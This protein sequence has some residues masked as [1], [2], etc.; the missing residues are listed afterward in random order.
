M[1]GARK[2]IDS[3]RSPGDRTAEE[4]QVL[5]GQRIVQAHLLLQLGQALGRDR[6][7]LGAGQHQL[8]RIARQ[9][10]HDREAR[11]AR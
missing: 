4:T 5:H 7:A 10:V 1:T 6:A 8:R 9:N 11:R 2:R 3:P